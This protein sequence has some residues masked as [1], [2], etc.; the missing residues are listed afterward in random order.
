M[1]FTFFYVHV[2]MI[3]I[4]ILIKI[5]S[6]KFSDDVPCPYTGDFRCA[7]NGYCIRNYHVCDGYEHCLDGSDEGMN[8]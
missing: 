1:Y 5:C 8:C 3:C 7:Y 6:I 4:C 2:Y